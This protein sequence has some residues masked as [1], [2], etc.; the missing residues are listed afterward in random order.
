MHFLMKKVGQCN[1]MLALGEAMVDRNLPQ[2]RL[3]LHFSQCGHQTLILFRGQGKS[4]SGRV[5]THAL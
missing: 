4:G 5:S 2:L 1:R 3:V